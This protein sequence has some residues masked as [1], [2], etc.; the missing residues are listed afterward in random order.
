MDNDTVVKLFQPLYSDLRPEEAFNVKKPLLAHYT[1]VQ[2]LEKILDTSELWFS[3]PLFMN[4]LEEVRFGILQ[5][6]SLVMQSVE[7]AEACKTTERVSIFRHSF[8]HYISQFD[9]Q[10][11]FNTYVFCT[12][13]HD[14]ENNDGLLSMWRGYGANGNGAAIVFDTAKLT[15]R[16]DSPLI[17][18]RVHYDTADARM[19]WL[20]NLLKRFAEILSTSAVP[21]GQ[22][23]LGAQSLFERIK[24]FALFTKH[25]GFMEERE[26][27]VVYLPDRDT[28]K[29]LE[30]M[31]NYLIS[32]RGIE[33]KLRFK[34][35]PVPG[36]TSD[37]LSLNSLIDRII[38]G[39]SISSPLARS[40]VL[41]MFDLLKQS[42]LAPK[43]WASTIPFRALG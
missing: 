22:L 43:L 9:M 31:F 42:N 34:V 23:F 10:H 35:L 1:T 13:E 3:N 15:P 36:V 11:L 24:L 29:R 7:I 12:S 19:A 30:P 25:R 20:K 14:A 40:S 8:N 17:I 6:N 21:D 16:P 38:L 41:R 39:P 4:D 28:Q 32:S 37:D 2:V 33:P 18:G 26:W 27:R 5:G